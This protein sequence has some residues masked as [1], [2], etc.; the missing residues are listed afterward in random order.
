MFIVNY[1]HYDA[2]L[3]HFI[4]TVVLLVNLNLFF[5]F[6]VYLISLFWD[7]I[8]MYLNIYLYIAFNIAFDGQ[9]VNTYIYIFLCFF[10]VIMSCT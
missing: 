7:F 9:F 8:F 1:Y 2:I 10:N 6:N 4:S 5:F 3:L